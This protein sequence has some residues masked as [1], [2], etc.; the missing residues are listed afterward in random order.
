MAMGR[1]GARAQRAAVPHALPAPAF[2]GP[3]SPIQLDRLSQI[4]RPSLRAAR[5]LAH[6]LLSHPE[7]E[8]SLALFEF[9]DL[10]QQNDFSGPV[11]Q[12][13]A[14]GTFFPELSGQSTRMLKKGCA[15][16]K[17]LHW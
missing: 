11:L 16:P 6:A 15:N 2:P 3:A 1:G 5:T 12:N 14:S 7:F 9:L 10:G 17:G 8:P 4:P 13:E